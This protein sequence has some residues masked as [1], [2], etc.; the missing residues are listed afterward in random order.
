MSTLNNGYKQDDA[1]QNETPLSVEEI[2]QLLADQSS[3]SNPDRFTD[4]F[5]MLQQCE[6]CIDA[7]GYQAINEI[8]IADMWGTGLTEMLDLTMH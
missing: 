4:G 5:N 1:F 2:E 7:A 3:D 6:N 8:S